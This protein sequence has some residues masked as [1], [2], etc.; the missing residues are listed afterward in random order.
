MS[1][2]AHATPQT[3]FP[4]MAGALSE[5]LV[6]LHEPASPR[7]SDLRRLAQTLALR[8]FNEERPCT[9]VSVIS[10]QRGEGRSTVAANLACAFALSGAKVLLIDADLNAPTQHERFGLRA[11]EDGMAMEQR[12]EGLENL[13]VISASTL[14]NLEL[15]RFL[16]RPLKA[17]IERRRGEFGA[18]IVDTASADTSND[19]QVAALATGGAVAVTREGCTKVRQATH[20]LNSCEDAG[21][22]VLGGVMLRN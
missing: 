7:A 11:P 13:S 1:T 12:V 10:A 4:A 8:S 2:L 6:M 16:Q 20:M 5:D 15:T 21:V 3:R 17:L 22:P 9:S 19:Y 18:I 14:E